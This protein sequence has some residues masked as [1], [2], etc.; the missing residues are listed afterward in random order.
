[1]LSNWNNAYQAAGKDD[2]PVSETSNPAETTIVTSTP[3]TSNVTTSSTPYN[4]SQPKSIATT[5]KPSAN[6][7]VYKLV[8]HSVTILYLRR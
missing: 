3:S 6:K 4:F 5:T 2:Q 7:E 1:M 8:V